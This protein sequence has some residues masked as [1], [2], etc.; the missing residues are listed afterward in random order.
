MNNEVKST[1][2]SHILLIDGE[3]FPVFHQERR[4][5]KFVDWQDSRNRLIKI[6]IER[7][8]AE[9]GENTAFI[10][11][12]AV[13]PMRKTRLGN[14]FIDIKAEIMVNGVSLGTPEELGLHKIFADNFIPLDEAEIMQRMETEQRHSAV[15]YEQ[16][17]ETRINSLSG[18]HPSKTLREVAE[19]AV[20]L[21]AKDG[22]SKS[23]DNR[24]HA[25]MKR[26][27]QVQMA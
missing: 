25:R 8:K 3:R 6:M 16:E 2:A 11:F 10:H 23:S 7:I 14:F 24:I 15:Q 17:L 19:L 1:V 18:V 21:M 12:K 26:L 9:T 20:K 27:E 13:N 22:W 5:Y 4:L